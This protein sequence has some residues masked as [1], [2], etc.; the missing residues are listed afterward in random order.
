VPDLIHIQDK[1]YALVAKLKKE[2]PLKHLEIDG[3]VTL[4]WN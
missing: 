3:R 4:K 2:D 1:R